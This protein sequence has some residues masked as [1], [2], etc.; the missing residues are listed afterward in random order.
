MGSPKYAFTHRDGT[1]V[2]VD[3]AGQVLSAELDPR[4]DPWEIRRERAQDRPTDEPVTYDASSITLLTEEDRWPARL[5]PSVA[6]AGVNEH[7]TPL[8]ALVAKAKR[9]DD[10]L[11]AALEALTHH[12]AGEHGGLYELFAQLRTQLAAGSRMRGLLDAAASLAHG[13]TTDADL[14]ARK[15]LA[16]FH[17]DKLASKPIGIYTDTEDMERVFRHDRILQ[18]ELREEDVAAIQAA[19][20]A[21]PALLAEYEWHQRIT[22]T[23]TGP[24]VKRLA[25]LPP[26]DSAE[27]R[28]IKALFGFQPIPD[29]FELGP[30]LVTRIRDGR[31]E[32][33]PK[34]NEGW[35]AH[36]FHAIAALLTPDTSGIL[37]GPRYRKE[38]EESFKALFA[39]NR[40]THVKQLESPAAA[41][42]PLFI[43]PR[44]SVEPLPEY[45]ARTAA[46]YGFLH[47]GLTELF[48]EHVLGGL[49]EEL[50]ENELLFRG[51]EATCRFELAQSDGDLPARAAFRAW[52]KRSANDPDLHYDLRVAVPVWFDVERK[53]TRISVT[54]GFETRTLKLDFEERP[55]VKVYGPATTPYFWSLKRTILSPL[56]IECDVQKPP[57]RKE[58]REICDRE[59]T[60]A[61][62]KAALQAGNSTAS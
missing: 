47:A 35:Y 13:T 54:L 21:S 39:L 46:A 4:S 8:F 19:L 32:T 9:F 15:W 57:T 43:V 33:T 51:A 53:T 34:P 56:T 61:A 31:L 5:Y 18:T 44:I 16:K 59:K 58:L 24:L 62:I 20:H 37:I 28:L 41:G 23:V 45:Y 29:G 7:F 30:E 11:M 42:A 1:R 12:G 36:Q 25:V 27:N 2:V 48:G 14:N 26:S 17:A 38:L 22:T 49:A 50:V 40:E 55:E 52:Q 6:A 60:P 3:L 10:R